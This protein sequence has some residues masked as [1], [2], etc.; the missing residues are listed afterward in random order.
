MS[1]SECIKAKMK[2]EWKRERRVQLIWHILCLMTCFYL[3]QVNTYWQVNVRDWCY[4]SVMCHSNWS[5][6]KSN[7]SRALSC[8]WWIVYLLMHILWP[9]FDS[10]DPFL[11]EML[12]FIFI[13]FLLWVMLIAN[14]I[15]G[16]SFVTDENSFQKPL[17]WYTVHPGIDFKEALLWESMVSINF[18]VDICPNKDIYQG[19]PIWFILG[20]WPDHDIAAGILLAFSMEH[21]PE[22]ESH[23][24]MNFVNQ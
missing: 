15:N 9:Y 8:N 24:N 10:K 7:H 19:I 11:L 14:M 20:G 21:I 17:L 12:P 5:R 6:K 23:G 4:Y 18:I 2:F 22:D 13:L 3:L 1:P 16:N